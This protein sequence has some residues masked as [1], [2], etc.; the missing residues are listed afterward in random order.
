MNLS[1]GNK[2]VVLG[3]VVVLLY[4]SMS[5]FIERTSA[6]HAFHSKAAAVTVDVKGTTDLQDD[7][8]TDMRRGPAYRTGGIYFTNYYAASYVPVP[9]SFRDAAYGMRL[10]AWLFALFGIAVGFIVGVQTQAS[11][12]LRSWASWLAVLAVVLYPVRDTVAF[13]GRWLNPNFTLGGLG[14]YVYPVKWIGGGAM[15]LSLLLSLVVFIQGAR[16]ASP[17]KGLF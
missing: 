4:L 10:Y 16:H 2:N 5:F 6:L 12:L 13:W 8:V 9:N 3:V 1:M 7:Q 14:P 11:R 17:Q 15:F